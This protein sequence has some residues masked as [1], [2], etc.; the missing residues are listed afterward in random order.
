M[1]ASLARALGKPVQYHAM[2][3][4]DYRALGFP[5]AE[6]LG[7]MFQYYRDFEAEFCASRSVEVSKRLDPQLLGFDAWCRANAARIPTS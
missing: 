6:D 4:A 2:S 7:N 1:A 5:G 3:P